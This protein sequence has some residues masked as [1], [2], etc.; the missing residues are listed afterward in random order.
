[1]SVSRTVSNG[2]SF[3]AAQRRAIVRGFCPC[4]KSEKAREL[5]HIQP[6][7]W[8]GTSNDDNAMA[9]CSR[10]HF[11]KSRAE[12]AIQTAAQAER[13]VAKWHKIAF[14][15]GGTRRQPLPDRNTPEAALARKIARAKR[16]GNHKLAAA[17]RRSK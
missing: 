2:R 17:L 14:T 1:M 7:I 11:E 8:G 5:D 16:N 4:C 6:L 3:T 15:A 10:C 9:L 13:H 12:Q